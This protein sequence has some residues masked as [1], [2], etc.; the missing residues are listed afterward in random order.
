MENMHAT[1][2]CKFVSDVACGF[3]KINT[4]NKTIGDSMK[5]KLCHLLFA[6][7]CLLFHVN[8]SSDAYISYNLSSMSL[9]S[10]KF[11]IL[12]FKLFSTFYC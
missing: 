1:N 12:A 6:K 4:S 10:C 3:S 7:F 2:R 5:F 11:Y 8:L 9:T